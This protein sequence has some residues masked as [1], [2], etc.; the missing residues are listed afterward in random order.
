MVGRVALQRLVR[1]HFYIELSIILSGREVDG[2]SQQGG[3]A[4]GGNKITYYYIL[5][6]K[7]KVAS[8]NFMKFIN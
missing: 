4:C 3:E 5:Y 7:K 2:G 1:A 8:Y 6:I